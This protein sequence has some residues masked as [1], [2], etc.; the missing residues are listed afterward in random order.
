MYPALQDALSRP[1]NRTG[2]GPQAWLRNTAW[3]VSCVQ[4]K[5]LQDTRRE[6][7]DGGTGIFGD[8]PSETVRLIHSRPG[9]AE[10]CGFGTGRAAP[11]ESA[12][13]LKKGR[14]KARDKGAAQT[15]SLLHA[16]SGRALERG[17]AE[18]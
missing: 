9:D 1:C 3:L 15:R 6:D 10:D 18:V 13:A 2:P 12:R 17:F 7:R 11:G 16:C 14:T 5:F 4:R 8:V